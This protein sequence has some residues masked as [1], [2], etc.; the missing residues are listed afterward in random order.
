MVHEMVKI[1][2]TEDDLKGKYR[3][4]GDHL[5]VNEKTTELKM[6]PLADDERKN[7]QVVFLMGGGGTRLKHV[8]KGEISK[9]MINV[10][11]Q[12]ISQFTLNLWKENGFSDFCF[13]IDNTSMG[14]SIQD[15]YGN[16]E[17]LGVSNS[18]SV[19][20]KKMGS[21]GAIKEAIEKNII[22]T[23]FISHQPDDLIVNY[24]NFADDFAKVFSAAIKAG[25]HIVMVCVPGTR[26]PYGEVVDDNGKV[27][28]FVEKPFIRKDTNTG[29][30][31]VSSGVFNLIKNIDMSA[32]PVKIE[33]SV[34]KTVAQTGK[35]LK[36]ILP[37]EYWIPVNDEP[38]LNKFVEIITQKH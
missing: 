11:G 8:T 30:V 17:K 29:V 15:F 27:T 38:N 3:Q 13:L 36:V 16:G 9:H 25:Y 31:G 19:E 14:K 37:S 35:I 28:D 2:N 23:S 22:K 12:P 5:Y 6:L 32:G 33:R 7:L 18:Y 26:Y 34:Y 21:G 1:E 4:V 20:Q 10:N 24:P